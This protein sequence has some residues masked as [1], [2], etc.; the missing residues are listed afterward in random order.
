MLSEIGRRQQEEIFGLL[1]NCLL[2]ITLSKRESKAEKMAQEAA[3]THIAALKRM[4][5]HLWYE[6]FQRWAKEGAENLG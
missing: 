5:P 3:E 1:S 6:D 4:N 2:A